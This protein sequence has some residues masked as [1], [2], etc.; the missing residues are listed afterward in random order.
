MSARLSNDHRVNH[1]MSQHWDEMLDEFRALGG[2]AD[3][4]RLGE[5]RF[6]RGL[7]PCDPSKPVKV[8]IPD[9]LLVEVG[10]I[11]FDNDT[12]RLRPDTPVGARERV[13]LENYQRDFS[14]GV[15]RQYTHDLLQMMHEAPTE[16][17][18]LLSTPFGAVFWLVDPTPTSIQERYFSAR[19]IKYK[20]KGVLMPIVELANHGKATQYSRDDGV[21][22]SGQFDGEILAR[23]SS[24]DTLEIF[25]QWGFASGEPNF[26]LSLG[27][28]IDSKS[29]PIRIG[30]SDVNDDTARKPFFPDVSVEDGRITLSY[31]MLGHKQ[32]PRLAKGIF[33]RIM[34]DAGRADAEET[35]DNIHHINRMQ[36]YKL[37]A[38]SEHAAPR[39]GHLLRD[40]ARIQLDA[41]SCS[42]GTREV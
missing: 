10:Y 13:F 33:Y 41:M 12:F 31:L 26:A 9:S 2:T 15:A 38:A 39:L 30:R 6:G 21:G 22:I 1:H 37:L 3:N 17:R 32:Y 5:G 42:V 29:G 14:W 34:R 35:F 40:V 18:E 28:E 8:H 7:F 36:F 11:R 24:S 19:Y 23:Y 27:M 20:G 25:K 16:L 4:V